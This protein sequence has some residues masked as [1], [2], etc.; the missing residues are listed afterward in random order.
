MVC[1][2]AGIHLPQYEIAFHLSLL[3]PAWL[4]LAAAGA[5]AAGAPR[6]L[7]VHVAQANNNSPYTFVHAKFEPGE[8]AVP[9]AVRST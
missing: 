9:W 3:L 5:V 2:I 6:E 8:V 7:K 4:T 1:E